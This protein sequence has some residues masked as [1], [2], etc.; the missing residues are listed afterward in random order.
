MSIF[1]LLSGFLLAYRYADA[2]ATYKAYLIARIARIYPIYVVAAVVTLPWLGVNFDDN[3]RRAMLYSVS[4]IGLLIVSNIFLIQAWFPPYFDLWN[5]GA[6]WSISVE[7]FCYLVLPMSFPILLNATKKKLF[8]VV[9]ICY[10]LAVAPGISALLYESPL[11]E[12]YYYLPIFRLP[13]VLIGTCI[14][15]ATR[16]GYEFRCGIA[17]QVMVL[18]IFLACLVIVGRYLPLYIGS[19]WFALPAIGFVIF[20]LSSDR[21]AASKFLSLPVFLRLGKISYCFYS[22]QALFLLLLIDNHEK[23]VK[24]LPV[25]SNNKLLATVVFIAL[26]SFS[27]V[28]YHLIERPATKWINQKWTKPQ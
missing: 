6:S 5:N 17:V 26:T 16:Q 12:I 7:A 2:S 25:F 28:G 11:N 14:Y 19:N 13:E 1:F 4:K 23:L 10:C 9:L 15:F 24:L 21:G 20:S 22:F 8:I 3:S 18:L 27:A